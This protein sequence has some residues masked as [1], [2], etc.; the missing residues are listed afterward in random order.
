MWDESSDYSPTVNAW[1]AAL[2]AFVRAVRVT[3]SRLRHR[4]AERAIRL[5]LPV[6]RL[7]VPRLLPCGRAGCVGTSSGF[8]GWSWTVR[9]AC[10]PRGG[11]NGNG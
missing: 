10:L 8:A 9:P 1:R 3:A 2:S 6:A 11:P 7:L 5:P 4:L